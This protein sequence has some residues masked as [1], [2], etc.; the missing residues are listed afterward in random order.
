[1]SW[2]ATYRTMASRLAM[3]AAED[4]TARPAQARRG[5]KSSDTGGIA[6]CMLL[7]MDDELQKNK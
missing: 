1:M 2:K 4:A 3:K 5:T 7:I 6:S